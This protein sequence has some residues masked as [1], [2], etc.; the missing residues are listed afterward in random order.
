[1][2]MVA[3]AQLDKDFGSLIERVEDTVEED[4]RTGPTLLGGPE[5]DDRVNLLDEGEAGMTRESLRFSRF[6]LEEP[7]GRPGP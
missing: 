3:Q 5:G 7:L 2:V 1:M 4:G 6:L